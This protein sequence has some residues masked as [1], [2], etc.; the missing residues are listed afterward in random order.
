MDES[1]IDLKKHQLGKLFM[2]RKAA[3][4]VIQLCSITIYTFISDKVTEFLHS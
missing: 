2:P 3:L 4:A 1:F